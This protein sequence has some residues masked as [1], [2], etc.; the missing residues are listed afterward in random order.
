MAAPDRR[1][2]HPDVRK[3]RKAVSR[4]PDALLVSFKWYD[5]FDQCRAIMEVAG[6]VE[7]ERRLRKA[8][9]Q[10]A[11]AGMRRKVALPKKKKAKRK[12]ET[13]EHVRRRILKG[14]RTKILKK[15]LWNSQ[16]IKG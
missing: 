10:K 1:Q 2:H 7:P 15:P 4:I 3:M 9:R 6:L 12:P 16:L 14:L 8:W 5:D 13:P 11:Q